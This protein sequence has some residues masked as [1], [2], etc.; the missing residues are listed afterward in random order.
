MNIVLNIDDEIVKKVHKIA[1]HKNT[2]LAAM[3]K[4]YLT[5][6]SNADVAKRREQDAHDTRNFKELLASCP[7]NGI[8]L[9]RTRD[10]PRDLEL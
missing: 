3:V 4:D 1:R 2:T 6:V 9:T 5:S 10:F 7:L 8:D